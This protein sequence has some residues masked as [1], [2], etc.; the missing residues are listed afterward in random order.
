MVTFRIVEC[1]PCLT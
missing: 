1:H